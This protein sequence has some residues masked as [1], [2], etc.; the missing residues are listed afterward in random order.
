MILRF[1]WHYFKSYLE[2]EK[3]PEILI[4]TIIALHLE[5]EIIENYSVLN[6]KI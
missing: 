6:A 2:T 3:K 4:K 1:V 5:K